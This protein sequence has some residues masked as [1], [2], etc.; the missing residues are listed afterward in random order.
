[1]FRLNEDGQAKLEAMTEMQ[2]DEPLY[3]T[4]CVSARS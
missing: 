1:M 4:V 3:Q 2:A